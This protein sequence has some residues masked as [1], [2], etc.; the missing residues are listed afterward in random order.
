MKMNV[1]LLM[2]VTLFFICSGQAQERLVLA[3]D[4][5]EVSDL[6]CTNATVLNVDSNGQLLGAYN[7]NVMGTLYDVVFIDNRTA[8]DLFYGSASFDASTE[9]HGWAFALALLDLVLVDTGSYHFDS[10]HNNTSGCEFVDF[11]SIG[12]PLIVNGDLWGVFALNQPGEMKDWLYTIT[13]DFDKNT[14][15]SSVIADWSVSSLR[16]A[17]ALFGQSTLMMPG[18]ASSLFTGLKTWHCIGVSLAA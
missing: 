8:K 16:T 7:V 18:A 4:G 10:Q 15:Q 5:T 2:L 13:L 12:T 9:M 1:S 11:C 14:V 6:N 17:P 3:S